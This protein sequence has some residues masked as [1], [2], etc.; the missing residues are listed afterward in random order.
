MSGGKV[1]T[2]RREVSHVKAQKFC[3]LLKGKKDVGENAPAVERIANTVSSLA[4]MQKESLIGSCL[5]TTNYKVME[6]RISK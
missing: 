6:R 4:T 1:S 3:S 5:C 2:F